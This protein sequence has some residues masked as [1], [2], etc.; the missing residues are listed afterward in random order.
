[1]S[2][3]DQQDE[4]AEQADTDKPATRPVH[5][6]TTTIDTTVD[7]EVTAAALG[8]LRRV[9]KK[10]AE[11]VKSAVHDPSKTIVVLADA[12]MLAKIGESRRMD[13]ELGLLEEAMEALGVPTPDSR[14]EAPLSEGLATL[15]CTVD[16]LFGLLSYLQTD[17]TYTGRAIAFREGILTPVLAGALARLDIDLLMPE[18]LSVFDPRDAGATSVFK[19]MER[20]NRLATEIRGRL[21][22]SAGAG[23]GTTAVP[24]S[25]ESNA[26]ALLEG[27]DRMTASMKP[28]ASS[29]LDLQARSELIRLIDAADHAYVLMTDIIQAGGHLRTRKNAFAS[30]LGRDGVTVS[31]GVAVHF[32][33]TDLKSMRVA[34]GDI[35]YDTS[36]HLPLRTSGTTSA[37][38][39]V[40][41]SEAPLAEDSTAP[42]ALKTNRPT[43][44]VGDDEAAQDDDRA[45]AAAQAA[46][47][48]MDEGVARRDWRTAASLVQLLKQVDAMAPRRRKASDGT[49]GDAAHQGRDS[50][51]NP[52]IVDGDVGVVTALDITNDPSNGCSAQAIAEAIHASRDGRVKYIIWNRMIANFE[53]KGS[54]PAWAWRPY[55]GDNPHNKHIHISVRA[56]K[57]LYDSTASW[58]L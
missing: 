2:E 48:A 46:A 58:T 43:P 55:T 22:I 6:G 45:A 1:M 4:T 33:L 44:N 34:C 24:R 51:H 31:G 13:I 35:V 57:P 9:A 27:L 26:Q 39:N 12:A 28:P 30:L 18:M 54:A 25:G 41:E 3:N 21:P 17:T 16:V 38:S 50:D 10:I 7:F 49:V 37:F 11:R 42:K 23:D 5:P 52:W 53:A 15:T 36:A 19:R 56:Q 20:L 47:H 32:T 29:F 14:R 40:E 8:S